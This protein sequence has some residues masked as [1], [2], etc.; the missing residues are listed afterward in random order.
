MGKVRQLLENAAAL[1]PNQAILENFIHH[2][3]LKQFESMKWKDALEYI[4]QLESYMSPV[5]KSCCRFFWI[6]EK[7]VNLVF[8]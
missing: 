5:R 8:F 4:Q 3:P 7:K 6:P 1:L 2:N